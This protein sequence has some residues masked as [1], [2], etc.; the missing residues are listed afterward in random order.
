MAKPVH[1]FIDRKELLNW[2][3]MTLKRSKDAMTGELTVNV[4]MGWLPDEPL[5][6][7][8]TRGRE[9]LVYIGGKL[10]F[11]GSIDRRRDTASKTAVGRDGATAEDGSTRTSIGP[12]SYEVDFSA[13]GKTKY[14]IDSSHQHPTGNILRPTAKEA[15]EALIKPWG[16]QLVWNADNPKFDKVR[17]RDGGFVSDELQRIA[18]RASLFLTETRDGRL[19][20]TGVDGGGDG[21][22]IILGTNV[23]TFST[24]QAQDISKT[25]VL[26]KG[27]RTETT[28]WGDSA[29]IPSE[30]NTKNSI[31][32]WFTPI[33]VRH[34]GNATQDELRNRAQYEVNKRARL[35]KKVTV[36][37][38]SITQSNGEPW[39]IGS[40]HYVELPPAN[41]FDVLE[42]IELTY[43][44][45]AQG[46]LKTELV[47]SPIGSKIEPENGGDEFL[48]DVKPI[49]SSDSQKKNAKAK[50]DVTGDDEEWGVEDFIVAGFTREE[51]EDL[52]ILNDVNIENEIPPLELPDGFDGGQQ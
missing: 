51:A 28:S 5:M 46:T 22:P 49:S 9:I 21:E 33:T 40:K 36:E 38:F 13:R 24:D 29:V 16:V 52:A 39:D 12:T 6:V 2:T 23:L 45:D 19:Q 34:Y 15:I 8:A 37:V 11:T 44:V 48:S 35:S 18:Q 14:L 3:G 25:E 26:V 50:Y 43:T 10:A 32:D 42:I 17:F 20:V 27:K 31:T 41:V 47:L 7:E 30:I 1:I 4:F